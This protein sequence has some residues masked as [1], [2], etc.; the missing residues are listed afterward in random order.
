MGKVKALW[1]DAVDGL[2]YDYATGRLAYGEFFE[3]MLR[4]GFD[5]H[6]V[7]PMAQTTPTTAGD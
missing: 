6:D 3:G 7:A 1:Q 4:L 2:Q 5:P